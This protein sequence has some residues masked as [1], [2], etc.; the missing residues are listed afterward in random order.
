MIDGP[1]LWQLTEQA[2]DGML[3]LPIAPCD[4]ARNSFDFALSAQIKISGDAEALL[5]LHS[6]ASFARHLAATMYMAES[7]ALEEDEINDALGELVNIIAG[8][9]KGMCPG[10]TFL[11]LP[12]VGQSLAD[13]PDTTPAENI[14]EVRG[15]C[16]GHGFTMR[17]A[18]S[19][20]SALPA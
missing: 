14:V 8:N 12:C 4:D 2:C 19:I 9:I 16:E 15:T 3:G 7:N 20:M 10:E 6:E 5:S 1:T 13:E 18:S 17:L 11:S